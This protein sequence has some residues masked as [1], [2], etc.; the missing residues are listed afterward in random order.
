M[1]RLPVLALA[2]ASSAYAQGP[3]EEPA[4]EYQPP[5]SEGET[6][7]PL[8]DSDPEMQALMQTFFDLTPCGTAVSG[9]CHEALELL[10]G[11][12]DRLAAY[13]I[14]QHEQSEAEG[15]L[16]HSTYLR[17]LGHTESERAVTYL[18]AKVRASRAHYDSLPATAGPPPPAAVYRN[19]VT[20]GQTAA[21][22]A[23]REAIAKNEARYA[24]LDALDA[25]GRTRSRA[26]IPELVP[27]L[28]PG[29]EQFHISAMNGL[30]RVQ[31]KHGALAEVADPLLALRERKEAEAAARRVAN[32]AQAAVIDMMKDPV[33]SR[34]DR[35]LDEPGHTRP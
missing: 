27:A 13:L 33:T 3:V 34:L 4:I 28:G 8:D 23:P 6:L 5:P 19:P 1:T 16:N 20:D 26:A 31:S 2:L 22:T 10:T 14:R 21:Y 9:M 7:R 12:G 30:D 24:Y 32:P 29:Q 35:V 11:G 15:F 18:V 25:L 17:L